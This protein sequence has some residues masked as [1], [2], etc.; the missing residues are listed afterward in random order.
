MIRAKKPQFA[1][2]K[3]KYKRR[4]SSIALVA[5]N[6]YLNN[7][8]S[9]AK[10]IDIGEFDRNAK[11]QK[12]ALDLWSRIRL[13]WNYVATRLSTAVR[14]ER[15]LNSK[16]RRDLFELLFGMIRQYRRIDYLLNNAGVLI[17]PGTT[18]ELARLLIYRLINDEIDIVTANNY[19]K[20]IDWQKVID[21]NAN[22]AKEHN[23]QKRIAYLHSYP[24]WL[25]KRFIKEFNEEAE[26]LAIALN[27]RANLTL[28][29]N[30]SKISRKSLLE[31]F[32]EKKISAEAGQ[33]SDQAI[34]LKSHIDVFGLTEYAE[35]LFETQDEGSQLIAALIDAKANDIV[36]DVC[37]G[38]GGKT[39]AIAATMQNKGSIWALDIDAKKLAALDKRARHLD[40]S[41]IRTLST[42]TDNWPTEIAALIGKVDRVLVD[43]PCTGTGALRRNPENR[44][45][46]NEQD[47]GVLAKLQEKLV[48][49]SLSLLAKGGRLV[50]ATCSL[51]QEENEAVIARVLKRASN[52]ELVPINKVVK[53]Q[54][55]AQISDQQ[56]LYLQTLPHT[57]GSDGFFAAVLQ[58]VC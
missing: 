46:L 58:R 24:D 8:N 32:S 25:T 16:E 56:G 42:A 38:V 26:P 49:R 39:F 40:L 51:L 14:Q 4:S 50:Y 17:P 1:A 11:L 23:M 27:Q 5:E 18:Y 28:R 54:L 45:R 22:L 30:I 10:K 35:G 52:I 15:W 20:S 43:A 33:F 6:L 47:I 57:H 2:K 12:L 44:W 36:V 21:S 9:R 3:K 7:Y 34:I 29:C 55:A 48:I 37:A 31:R 41:I 19:F 53:Q 13:D